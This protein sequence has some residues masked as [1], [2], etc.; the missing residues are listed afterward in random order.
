MRKNFWSSF[1]AESGKPLDVPE[2]V[3]QGQA[4]VVRQIDLEGSGTTALAPEGESH[5]G[6]EPELL[7]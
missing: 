5:A 6:V 2:F 7:F 3:C 1:W 4:E